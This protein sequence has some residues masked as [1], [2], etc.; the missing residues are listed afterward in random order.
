MGALTPLNS[1]G[2]NGAGLRGSSVAVTGIV[3]AGGGATG[4]SG[5]D[6]EA[7]LAVM[8][9]C[10]GAWTVAGRCSSTDSGSAVATDGVL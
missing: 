4:V 1:G 6:G 3:S 7:L 5:A 2:R 9:G 8:T 10:S